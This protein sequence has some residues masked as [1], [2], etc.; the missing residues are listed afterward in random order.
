M[1]L[2]R[3]SMNLYQS[4]FNIYLFR[5]SMRNFSV[6]YRDRPESPQETAVF[7]IEYVIRNGKNVLR[8]KAVDMK[9]WQVD[10]LDVYSFLLFCAILTLIIIIYIVRFVFK[11][12]SLKLYLLLESP[13]IKNLNKKIN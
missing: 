5:E 8:S 1:S 3:L 10:L 7:W 9:W 6:L 4:L 2:S 11:L 13:K 12:F